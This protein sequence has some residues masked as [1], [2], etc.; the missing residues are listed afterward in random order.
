MMESSENR[1][2]EMSALMQEC[3]LVDSHLI[4]DLYSETETYAR[5]KI[6]D[7]FTTRRI[8]QSITYTKTTPY[9]EWIMSN[10]VALVVDVDYKALEAGD[11]VFWQRPD[12]FQRGR[13]QEAIH[14]RMVS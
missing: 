4:A 5:G 12:R 6:D 10:H 8:Q 1:T 11:L 7:I 14:Q 2:D 3:G 9:N 13:E